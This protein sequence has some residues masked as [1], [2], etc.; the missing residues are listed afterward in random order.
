MKKLVLSAAIASISLAATA[1]QKNNTIEETIVTDTRV[2]Q[3]LHKSLASVSIV[4][5]A[6]IEASPALSLTDLL[7]TLPGV[8]LSTSGGRGSTSSIFTRGTSGDHTLILIDGVRTS[9]ATS[10]NTDLQRIPLDQIERIEVVRGPRSSLYGAEAIGGVV[11]IFT[12]QP[13]GAS[14]TA[15]AGSHDFRKA[16]FSIGGGDVT[17]YKLTAGH[18]KTNGFSNV[19][20]KQGVDSDSDGY[21]E[22]SLTA[23][24]SHRLNNDWVLG[25]TGSIV[26]AT[27]EFDSGGD[28]YTDSINQALIANAAG[29]LTDKLNASIQIGQYNDE[30]DTYGTNVSFFDT[31]RISA[32]GQI[33]YTVAKNHVLTLGYDYYDDEVDSSTEFTE[34]SRDNK[35][36]FTQYQGQIE[37]VSIIGSFRSDDNESFGTNNTR[38][39]SAG[40]NVSSDTLVTVSYGTAFKA[41]TFN[42][43]YYPFFDFG[44]FG[45]YAGN[46]DLKPEESESYELLVKSDWAGVQ[47]SASYYETNVDDLISVGY[48]MLGNGSPQNISNVKITGG[49]FGA[50]FD[51]SGFYF[52]AALSY[53][54]PRDEETDKL[55]DNRAREKATLSVSKQHGDLTWNVY[56]MTQSHRYTRSGRLAGY[57]T[58][59]LNLNYDVSNDLAVTLKVN[60]IFDTDYAIN[61]TFSGAEYNTPRAN[62]SLAVRYNFG[63]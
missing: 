14:V 38:S 20:T 44:I 11:Q 28:D 56:W 51:L 25:A 43:L 60:N 55:I 19:D 45:T 48:D 49:E 22:E 23:S 5:R 12:R 21:E 62:A 4:T 27:S 54:D 1:Q 24:V 15:E 7:V 9:S 34:E 40:Y 10:G 6:D 61:D 58:V 52:D 8:D 63:G 35:A 41:P 31:E 13:Q 53:T 17:R 46:P 59:D 36:Y 29:A 57:N 33:D 39:F 32:L 16:S 18:E 2:E 37:A 47:W 30:R 26:D 3:P 42:D 50:A